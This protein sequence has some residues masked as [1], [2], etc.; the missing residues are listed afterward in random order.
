L[1]N[2]LSNLP[3]KTV[4][5]VCRIIQAL[6]YVS[7]IEG[8]SMAT[9]SILNDA[10]KYLTKLSQSPL[11]DEEIYS[12]V[13]RNERPL[14]HFYAFLNWFERGRNFYQEVI[15][16]SLNR[17]KELI[18]LGYYLKG[19]LR[20]EEEFEYIRKVLRSYLKAIEQFRS[21]QRP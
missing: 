10:E 14:D 9:V 12:E 19:E 11:E 15:S 18:V 17:K 2:V 16:L 3:K 5:K 7:G 4:F 6:K 20:T 1:H 13:S 8:P 21:P